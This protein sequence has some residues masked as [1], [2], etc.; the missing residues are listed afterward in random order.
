MAISL[1][2][3]ISKSS[4]ASKKTS[5]ASK[6]IKNISTIILN[7]SATRK[8]ISNSI[9]GYKNRRLQ[10]EK[11]QQIEDEIRSPLA[12]LKPGG[13]RVLSLSQTGESFLTRILS[14]ITF[15][16]SGWLLSN[17]P[18]WT[19]GANQ[20]LRRIQS[21]NSTFTGFVNNIGQMM[22]D[23]GS[24]ANSFYQ[25]MISFDFSDS[26][27][28]VRNSLSELTTTLQ[29]M[30][31]QITEVFTVL[32]APFTNLPPI[33]SEGEPGAYPDVKPTTPAQPP[34]TPGGKS[35]FWI[36][37]LISLYESLSPQGAA[38]VAQSIY[39]RMGYSGR[40]ARQEILAQNQYEPVGKFGS[41][42]AWNKVVDRETAIAH[43]KKY[44]GNGVSVAGL[45]KVASTLTNK[46]A[47]QSAAKFVGNRPDFRSQGFENQY[48]DMTNDTT[49]YGQ[50]F[51][52]NK[53][54]AYVGKKST[55]AV[56][57]DFGIIPP[58]AKPSPAKPTIPS[59]VIDEINV[60]G[61][62]GGTPRVGR[63]GGRGEYLS[64][65]GKHKGIDIG[66]SGQKGYYVSFKQTGQVTFA[67]WNSG[68]YGYLVIIKS[69]DLEFFFA[70]LA[71]IMVKKGSQYNGQ[72]IGEIG[73]TGRSSGEHLHFEVR[74]VG[75]SN[76]DPEPYLSLLSIGRKFTKIS[77][78]VATLAPNA[79]PTI[80]QSQYDDI[81]IE[82]DSGDLLDEILKGMTP[83]R[84]GRQIVFINDISST[85]SK[86]AMGIGGKTQMISVNESELVNNFIKKK[87]LVDLSYL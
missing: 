28:R 84:K 49:R 34:S 62:S 10:N 83:E 4:S 16:S 5:L 70:H 11:R 35:D 81:T 2:G 65:G 72:T 85:F 15:V 30:G 57:P 36:L 56:V 6:T 1:L 24:I 69:G 41:T 76:I 31:D 73:N 39:N 80:L 19:A 38:D 61:P 64:R 26:N 66:T 75:G 22:I 23:I 33:G 45:D 27:Y 25:N 59:S 46:S 67:G 42:A 77:T 14:F 47:Q 29:S 21:L 54:S 79:K 9:L 71:K 8:N 78:P 50:T 18:T 37:A 7:R 20:L 12:V 43:I 48:D 63:T 68:G 52:F 32:T 13:S 53:G 87:L 17:M 3:G 51:G 60:A 55:A 40:T 86:T 58:T 74:K 44:P 82:S